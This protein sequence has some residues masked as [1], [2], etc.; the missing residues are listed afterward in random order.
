MARNWW[1]WYSPYENLAALTETDLAPSRLAS[2]RM[3]H[4]FQPREGS[5]KGDAVWCKGLPGISPSTA[6]LIADPL[7]AIRATSLASRSTVKIDI[8]TRKA[9]VWGERGFFR[10][11]RGFVPQGRQ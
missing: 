1:R 9:L 6:R 4:I 11:S 7:R 3:G 2:L 8:Y 5:P 10:A